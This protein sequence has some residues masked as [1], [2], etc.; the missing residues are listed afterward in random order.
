MENSKIGDLS[1]EAYEGKCQSI[2][3]R[4]TW[5]NT[6]LEHPIVNILVSFGTIARQTSRQHIARCCFATL[7]DGDNVIP[8]G[9]RITTISALAIKKH[10]QSFFAFQGDSIN[11]ALPLVRK[12]FEFMPKFIIG[13]ITF[14]S[15]SIGTITTSALLFDHTVEWHP[16]AATS[17]PCQALGFHLRALSFADFLDTSPMAFIASSGIAVTTSPIYRKIRDRSPLL[18]FRAMFFTRSNMRQVF[19]IFNSQTFR[20]RFYCAFF[21]AHIPLFY[22]FVV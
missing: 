5:F 9:S 16:F 10:C 7:T 3:K 17:A 20:C 2:K 6:S 15:L 18:A 1:V 4:F 22:Q 21:A 11:L 8:C 19:T 13:R 14:A 12:I